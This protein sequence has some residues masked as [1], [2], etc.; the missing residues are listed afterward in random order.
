MQTDRQALL[1]Y[2]EPREHHEAMIQI[3]HTITSHP[4][5]NVFTVQ[6]DTRAWN[7]AR[8]GYLRFV[9][10]LD[11]LQVMVSPQRAMSLREFIR[12]RHIIFEGYN[13]KDAIIAYLRVQLVVRQE[14]EG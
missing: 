2:A 7:E 6:L 5:R 10:M 8:S 14:G 3:P 1:V 4:Q 12:W 9:F 13:G 11:R